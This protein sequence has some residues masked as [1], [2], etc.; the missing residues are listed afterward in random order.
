MDTVPTAP[1]S[2]P[3][4][5]GRSI[6]HAQGAARCAHVRYNGSTCGCPALKGKPYCRFHCAARERKQQEAVVLEDAAALQLAIMRIVGDLETGDL[7]SKRATAR[8]YALQLASSN[9]TRLAE[10]LPT[11]PPP[12]DDSAVARIMV[13][14]DPPLDKY[15]H[16]LRKARELV[17]F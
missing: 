14:L 10:E 4:G 17:A 8:L 6:H 16:V 9:L 5:P 13:I 12:L 1:E 3:A 7:D 11:E 15:I 2:P